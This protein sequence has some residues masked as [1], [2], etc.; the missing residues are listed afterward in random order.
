MGLGVFDIS[1]PGR[2]VGDQRH[3]NHNMIFKALNLSSPDHVSFPIGL[4]AFD[5]FVPGR[6]VGDWRHE[7][8]SHEAGWQ[9]IQESDVDKTARGHEGDQVIIGVNS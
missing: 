7:N 4:G 6:L 2:L 1:V 5:I 3:E 8:R 9:G